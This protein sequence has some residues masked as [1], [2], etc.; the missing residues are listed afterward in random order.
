[1]SPETS[2]SMK[3]HHETSQSL[4]MVEVILMLNAIQEELSRDI[5]TKSLADVVGTVSDELNEIREIA[6]QV[7]Q[8]KD[9]VRH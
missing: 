9:A 7:A 1:M 8:E 3:F 5:V 4:T 2:N 6:V